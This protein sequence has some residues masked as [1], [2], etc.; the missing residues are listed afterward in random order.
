MRSDKNEVLVFDG[1]NYSQIATLPTGNQPTTMAISYDQ[2]YLLV[3]N[4][5]A[6]SVNVFDLDTLQPDTPIVLPSGFIAYFH[7]FLCQCHTRAGWFYD[8]TFHILQLDIPSRSGTQLPSL[9]VY[10]NVTNA[11]TV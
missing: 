2:Q 11:N 1:S 5:G 4:L 7:S 9:G 3:G 8:G 6:Q 10:T